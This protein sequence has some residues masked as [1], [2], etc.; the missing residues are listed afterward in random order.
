MVLL[1]SSS[2]L[3]YS[4]FSFSVSSSFF[5]LYRRINEDSVRYFLLVANNFGLVDLGG[6]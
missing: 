6:K 5:S 4:L 1:T 3:F 2:Y